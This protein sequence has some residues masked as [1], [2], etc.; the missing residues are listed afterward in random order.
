[1]ESKYS[2]NKVHEFWF[3]VNNLDLLIEEKYE[4]NFD[5]WFIFKKEKDDL[6]H[7]KFPQ[8]LCDTENGKLDH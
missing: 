5:L 4:H 3:S 8:V 2:Y 7:E 6:V 1:M